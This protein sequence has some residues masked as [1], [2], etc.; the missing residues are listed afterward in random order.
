LTDVTPLSL[1]YPD[2]IP[3][4]VPSGKVLAHNNVVHAS[5]NG[6][7][8]FRFWLTDTDPRYEVCPCDWASELPEHY[9]LRVG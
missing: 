2:R 6:T 3:S 5:R 4:V 8:G 9:T 1:D 7:R